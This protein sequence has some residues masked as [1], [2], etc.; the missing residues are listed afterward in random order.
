MSS[1]RQHLKP[2]KKYGSRCESFFTVGCRNGFLY[3]SKFHMFHNHNIVIRP[4]KP[5]SEPYS[6][7]A[8][9]TSQFTEMFPTMVFSSFREFEEKM[10]E[11]QT[12]TGCVYT[13][14]HTCPW[15]KD[16]LEHRDLVYK[17]LAYEC[18]HYG[19]KKESANEKPER[20]SFRTGCRSAVFIS[21][22]NNALHINRFEMRHNHPI[23][24]ASG[25]LYRSKRRL[26]FEQQSVVRSLLKK[27]EH[28][29]AIKQF[30]QDNF[31][32]C[33]TTAEVRNL[34][35]KLKLKRHSPHIPEFTLKCLENDGLADVIS[36]GIGERYVISFTTPNLI[37]TF[38][39][40]PEVLQIRPFGSPSLC[41]Y[42]F[43]VIDRKLESR[44][45][46]YSFVLD[47]EY[48]GNLTP[49]LHSFKNLMRRRWDDIE[50][51]F[52]DA[53][54]FNC[55]DIQSEF[56]LA[57]ILFYR[58]SVLSH[59]KDS[60]KHPRFSNLPRK[61]IFDEFFSAVTTH[62]PEEYAASL[63]RINNLG[64]SFYQILEQTLLPFADHWA[65]HLRLDKLTFGIINRNSDFLKHLESLLPHIKEDLDDCARRLLDFAA[66]PRE[67]DDNRVHRIDLR[68]Q[69]E[70]IQSLLCLLSDPVALVLIRHLEESLS[71]PTEVS[72]DPS[73]RNCSCSF[74][75]QWRLPCMHLL[76]AARGE[77][78]PFPSLL[79]D[80]RW[81]EQWSLD[82]R[83]SENVV[84]SIIEETN[85]QVAL[86]PSAKY[87]KLDEQLQSIQDMVVTSDEDKFNRR[88]RELKELER[89]WLQE[90]ETI[91]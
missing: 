15:P 73:I 48:A 21:C 79:K 28:E 36:N 42:D 37:K 64:P 86:L 11:F 84:E 14:R 51:I 62:D 13:K 68:G 81:L 2:S 71:S 67:E 27:N 78:I 53:P 5:K 85:D 89:R 3:V 74:N 56:P 12:K 32:V 77:Y 26:T 40:Y 87:I 91:S 75:L 49:I 90:D 34:K 31:D 50:T 33:M 19:Y 52:V 72:S 39:L 22:R 24:G 7:I 4:A 57:R 47:Y 18:F 70:D 55:S 80:S 38:N 10:E 17:K 60:L 44:T 46:M 35:R 76:N 66:A 6:A 30:I 88:Q 16:D 63:Q 69:P 29:I 65:E 43:S 54:P 82:Y 45:V 20:R 9:Y 8:D 83:E 25:N 23:S 1:F 58:D 61:A 41:A 59:V